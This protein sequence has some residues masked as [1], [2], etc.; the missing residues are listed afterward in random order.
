MS[1]LFLRWLAHLEHNGRTPLVFTAGMA[2][3]V[4]ILEPL[5]I[6]AEPFIGRLDD[7]PASLRAWAQQATREGT[8]ILMLI[9]GE[10]VP[11]MH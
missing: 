10:Y 11:V 9:D 2:G 1:P 3:S 4:Y 7:L 8:G 6:T 5:G